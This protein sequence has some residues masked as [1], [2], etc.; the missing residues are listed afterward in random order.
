VT[1]VDFSRNQLDVASRRASELGLAVDFVR[2]DVTDLSVFDDGRFDVVYTGGHVAVWVADMRASMARPAACS[3]RGSPPG[4]RVPPFPKSVAPFGGASGSGLVL[5]RSRSPRAAL[6]EDILE[7]AP[8]SF[9][10]YE[11]H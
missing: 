4:E 11:F 8:G 3:S 6:S 9:P 7:P 2:A 5:F 10:T 1:S